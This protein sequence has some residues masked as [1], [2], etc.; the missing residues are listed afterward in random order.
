VQE[1]LKRE[2]AEQQRLE[3]AKL[4]AEREETRRAAEEA[5][6]QQRLEQ[7]GLAAEREG[8]RLAAEG[9]KATSRG[10]ISRKTLC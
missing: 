9:G 3:Q 10:K 6:E 8:A 7:A 5:A 4:A 1:A 2:A